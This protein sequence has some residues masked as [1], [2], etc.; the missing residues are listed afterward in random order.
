MS[1]LV[2]RT[3]CR[4]KRCDRLGATGSAGTLMPAIAAAVSKRHVRECFLIGPIVAV[5][6]IADPV[7]RKAFERGPGQNTNHGSRRY[8]GH[9]IR[10]TTSV[11]IASEV[12]GQHS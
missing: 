4:R 11:G 2:H 6:A 7:V 8:I 12:P 3:V 9:I 1:D 10:N 5:Y